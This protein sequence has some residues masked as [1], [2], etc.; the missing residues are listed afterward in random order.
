ML[1][2]V[3][4][5]NSSEVLLG[6]Q[7]KLLVSDHKDLEGTRIHANALAASALAEKLSGTTGFSLSPD[8]SIRVKSLIAEVLWKSGEQ[9]VSVELLRVATQLSSRPGT[10]DDLTRASNLLDLGLRSSSAR[11]QKPLSI[12]QDYL[13][14]A[15]DLLE[16]NHSYEAGAIHLKFAS[17]CD[18]QL[19]SLSGSE[20]FTRLE[21][22]RNEKSR[23]IAALDG[24]IDT[25]TTKEEKRRLISQRT[26]ATALFEIDDTEY[27]DIQ[28]SR[29]MYLRRSI[30]SFL[31]AFSMTDEGDVL[32]SRCLA[33]WFANGNAES[34]NSVFGEHVDSVPSYK[35]LVVLDQLMARLNASGDSFQTILAKILSRLVQ[36]HPFHSLYGMYAVQYSRRSGD[37]AAR[38]RVKAI[39]KIVQSLATQREMELIISNVRSVCSN[40]VK[41]ANMVIDKKAFPN[42]AVPFSAIPNH[43]AFL[44]DFARLQVPPLTL[45]LP[46]RPSCD[47]SDIPTIVSYEN[48]FT[49]ASGI[50]VPKVLKCKVSD[51][52]ICKELVSH[53]PFEFYLLLT[54]ISGQGWQ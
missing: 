17:F 54:Q 51:G 40:Y 45:S 16:S 31:A 37:E 48:R 25:S 32:I 39:T 52:S 14:P 33:L 41:L 1:D 30:K 34:I 3:R 13:V 46:P 36:D 38:G 53:T 19:K 11:L 43:R 23:E 50:S 2:L 6:E 4:L 35:F 18:D 5:K 26:K 10:V 24:M 29:Q 15:I 47:Y 20:D 49:L 42:K 9:S 22:L 27:S 28:A 44:V 7:L 21:R 8:I 12:L